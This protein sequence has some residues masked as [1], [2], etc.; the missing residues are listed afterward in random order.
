MRGDD[1]VLM[2]DLLDRALDAIWEGAARTKRLAIRGWNGLSRYHQPRQRIVIVA[3]LFAVLLTLGFSA[4][5][6]STNRALAA[7]GAQPSPTSLVITPAL[8]PTPQAT[9]TPTV[10]KTLADLADAYT[11]TMSLDDKLGQLFIPTFLC[12][13]YT[14][15]DAIMVE[16]LHTGGFILY[17]A[18]LQNASQARALIAAAKAHSVIP[19]LVTL[20]EEGGGVDRL[21]DIYGPRPS[22]RT[23]ANSHSTAYATSQGA[24]V[25]R[26]MAALGFNVDFAPDVDVQ[27]V[28]GPDLGSRNFGTDPQTVITYAG[29][30][31]NGM[32]NNGVV[33]TLK[34][35]P[36]LGAATIDAHA[37]LPVINRTRAQIE[38]VELAPYRALIATG[39]V[40]AIMSTDLLMPALDPNLPAELSPTI[41]DGVL[42]H[43]LG[44]DGV[45]I[46][47]ALYMDG[48][49][50]H[51][52]MNEAGVLAILAGCDML[53]GPMTPTQM[54]G[55]INALK[56]ALT[57]GRLTQA[58]I[59]L[60]V[61]RILVLK[62]RMGLIPVPLS[63]IAPVPAIG[64]MQP[65]NG[66]GLVASVTPTVPAARD[67]RRQPTN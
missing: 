53:E 61:R 50:Q 13:G 37:G 59:D 18:N 1:A 34:H 19:P 2:I 14:K 62:M 35:F 17:S 11:A 44:F 43:D 42:R 55:M 65:V 64:S 57:N 40:G 52:S 66:P 27:L 58:R 32:Q 45:V 46:T 29:A 47:D 36:G 23:I 41:I 49:T 51:Y 9:P 38:Q 28:R 6:S 4:N 56:A 21:K 5:P 16:Q 63:A 12:C 30:Y 3:S 33:G 60:S 48:I 67:N 24:Q 20:D 31:L 39:Q 26:D 8:T 25:A 10:P 7:S 22:A 54:V 15:N